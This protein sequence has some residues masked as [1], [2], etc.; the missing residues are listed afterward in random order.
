MSRGPN[1][2]FLGYVKVEILTHHPRRWVWRVC[3]DINH[4]PVLE[5][6]APLTCAES[7]WSAGNK[8]LH[9]LEHGW[10]TEDA[11]RLNITQAPSRGKVMPRRARPSPSIAAPAA[12]YLPVG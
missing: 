4:M 10:I 8:A 6:K 5:A 2:K 12:D 7:A 11:V 1:D 3:K 9:A